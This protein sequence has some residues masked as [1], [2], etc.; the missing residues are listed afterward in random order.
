MNDAI[1]I[2]SMATIP[3]T[4]GQVAIVDPE[5]QE[6]IGRH[7]W[8]VHSQGYAVRRLGGRADTRIVFM[9]RELL[10]APDGSEI[11]HVNGNRLDNRR[12]NLRFATRSRQMGNTRKRT[13]PTS[14]R[15]KGVS[16]H[17]AAG[18]WTAQM[19]ANGKRGYLGLFAT[20]EAAAIAYNRAAQ[21]AFG[22]FA[23]I[24]VI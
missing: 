12:G 14:S 3:L 4:K 24:N 22:E 18:K 21:S 23:R 8:C 1:T 9:H 13:G 19:G 16:W 15:Y 17:K 10:D 7:K 2:Q 6:E 11:D 20:E 5:D